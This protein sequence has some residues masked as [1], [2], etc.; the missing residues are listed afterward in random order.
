MWSCVGT[1]FQIAVEKSLLVLSVFSG[2][3]AVVMQEF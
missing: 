1:L 3:A 2:T